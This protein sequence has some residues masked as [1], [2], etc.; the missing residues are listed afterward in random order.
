MKAN[1]QASDRVRRQRMLLSIALSSFF[2][3]LGLSAETINWEKVYGA[4]DGIVRSFVEVPDGRLIAGTAIHGIFVSS[5]KGATWQRINEED[6]LL[7]LEPRT[8]DADGILY[9]I[10]QSG[11]RGGIYRST[12]AGERWG[13]HNV[14][15]SELIIHN[16]ATANSTAYLA[17][18]NGMYRSTDQ[19]ESWHL[20]ALENHLVEDL[21]ATTHG[22]LYVLAREA[23]DPVTRLMQSTDN[24]VS[25]IDRSSSVAGGL[26]SGI[27]AFS[28]NRIALL[29]RFDGVFLSNEQGTEWP[30]L[31]STDNQEIVAVALHPDGSVH[32]LAPAAGLVFRA[33]AAGQR[34]ELTLPDGIARAMIIADTGELLVGF[35]YGGVWRST[36]GNS[37]QQVGMTISRPIRSFLESRNGNLYWGTFYFGLLRSTD[38]G[39]S[40]HNLGFSGQTG[41]NAIVED[42]AGVLFVGGSANDG[43]RSSDGGETWRQLELGEAIVASAEALLAASNDNIYYAAW[44][45]TLRS[46]DGGDSWQSI[47][48]LDDRRILDFAETPSGT[49]Y[50][51]SDDR[52][53]LLRSVDEGESWGNVAVPVISGVAISSMF[54]NSAGTVFIGAGFGA[55]SRFFLRSDNEGASWEFVVP[56]GS[57][58]PIAMREAPGERLFVSTFT[59]IYLSEDKGVTWSKIG[60][61]PTSSSIQDMYVS[62]NGRVYIST[63]E[64]AYRSREMV[65]V[66]TD[67]IAADNSLQSGLRLSAEEDQLLIAMET[68]TAFGATIAI[69]DNRG[70]I[71]YSGR[72]EALGRQRRITIPKRDWASGVYHLHVQTDKQSAVRTFSLLR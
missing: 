42:R 53:A 68:G 54:I 20:F 23:G 66:D 37:W 69:F 70:K 7:P 30:R 61:A 8:A 72:E 36:D 29:S 24:G 26:F 45:G 6:Q 35:T 71:L 25:W 27:S 64:G 13:R 56:R 40:W 49:L 55:N 41:I 10:E 39:A 18:E 47:A 58:F 21:A 59:E 17:T 33:D 43:Y 50:A 65:S 31:M 34:T 1:T 4:P 12:D 67:P 14:G 28:D 38:D 51:R 44:R 2:L 9:G 5:D 57:Y 22:M 3:S 60:D 46:S 52:G 15:V 48:E 11:E 62:G 16:V 19:G 63:V 32:A